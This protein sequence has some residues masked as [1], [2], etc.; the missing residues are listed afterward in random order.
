MHPKFKLN[1]IKSENPE[2]RELKKAIARNK[3]EAALE[4]FY[5]ERKGANA[6]DTETGHEDT[7]RDFLYF[8]PSTSFDRTNFQKFLDDEDISIKSLDNHPEIKQLFI[9]FN[10]PIPSSATVERMFSVANMILTTKRNR[11]FRNV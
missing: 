3:V 11:L 10:T 4:E 8:E 2:E 5:R 9:K 7:E 6:T 1:W